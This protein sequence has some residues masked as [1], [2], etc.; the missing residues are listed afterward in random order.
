MNK[1]V[2]SF[3]RRHRSLRV[4]VTDRCNLR[5]RYCMP[6][7]GMKFASRDE[8]LSFEDIVFAVDVAVSLGVHKIRITGGEPLLRS[9]L[10]TLIGMLNEQTEASNIAMTT[11]A[12]LL[13]RHARALADAGLDRV[14]ISLDSL[15]PERFSEVTRHGILEDVWTGI[16]AASDAGFSPIRINALL[17]EGFNDDEVD[18]WLELA[19]E[20]K[21]DVRFMEL[22]PIGEGA[23]LGRLG[24]F[25][26]LTA[27][28]ERLV[29]ERGLV[30]ADPDVGNGPAKYWREPGAAGRIGFI[31]PMSDSYCDSC[32]RMRLTAKGK[33]RACL[34]Y[35]DHVDARA[36]IRARDR[37][38]TVRCFR[39]SIDEKPAGHKW[40]DGQVT[41]T[42]MSALG[43]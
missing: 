11:N 12:L 21:L 14:N 29:D 5:C 24:E 15:D 10:P 22:M 17:L 19:R 42:G 35:D 9:E 13:E 34:A 33:L 6:A 41:E 43:G 37:E 40:R 16:E 8:L 30:P 32:S 2:D 7:E 31:T 26:N 20:H 1:L 25:L 3:G 28:R 39:R 36:M 23:E 18:D 38:A 27:L 4:S